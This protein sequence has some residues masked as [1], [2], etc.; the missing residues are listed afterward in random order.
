MNVQNC[1]P[2]VL[3]FLYVILLGC[4][5]EWTNEPVGRTS[6]AFQDWMPSSHRPLKIT[7]GNNGNVL[8]VLDN[9]SNV[10]YYKR[11]NIYDCAFYFEDYYSFSG[12]PNDVFFAGNTFYVQ[13]RA[14]L[15][16]KDG[17]EACYAKDG[18]FAVRGQELA[19][20]STAGIEIWEIKSN[21]VKKENISLQ[22][23][24]ALAAFNGEYYAAEAN[25]FASE[26]LN[27]AF[28]KNGVLLRKE[29]LSVTKGNE[30]NFCSADRIAANNN[31]I[32]LFDKTCRKIGVFDNQAYWKK[33]IS[34]DSL[35]IR[36]PLDIAA[37]EHSY[38]FILHQSGV[39][40][41]NAAQSLA[42]F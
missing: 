13:D 26:P 33:T 9:S 21:C 15:K 16:Y 40:K 23:V 28:Y 8:Y 1:M 24:L 36:N 25:G 35:G 4:G 11:D 6:C 37:G 38:I 20:G 19:V 14:Q 3:Y 29:P 12:F 5:G 30:K 10:H 31:G 34:L 27:L 39:E 32:F 17:K 22:S 7:M 18:F 42:A 2:K 41:I